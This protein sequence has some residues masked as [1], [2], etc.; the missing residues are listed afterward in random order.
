MRA[1]KGGDGF[2]VALEAE[3][4]FQFIGGQLKVG[5][6]LQRHKILEELTGCWRP[7]WTV[8]SPGELGAELRAAP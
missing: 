8:I 1:D 6:F 5:G 3:A 4:D 7:I 2:A